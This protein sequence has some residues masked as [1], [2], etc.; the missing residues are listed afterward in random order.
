MQRARGSIFPNIPQNLQELSAILQNPEW[1]ALLKTLDEED[2][3]YL[4]SA[5]SE[6]GSHNL[7]FVSQRCLRIMRMAPIIFADGTFFIK[8]SIDGCYQVI[9]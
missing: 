1:E 3:M 8:P 9:I 7:I 4:G 2:S 5:W 6:D